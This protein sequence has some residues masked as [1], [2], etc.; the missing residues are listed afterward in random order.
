MDVT[1]GSLDDPDRF[2]P[3]VEI[4]LKQRI[5]WEPLHPALPKRSESSLNAPD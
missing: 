1:T 4:W 2:P 5:G 3:D